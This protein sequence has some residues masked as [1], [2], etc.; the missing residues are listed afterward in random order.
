MS[1]SGYFLYLLVETDDGIVGAIVSFSTKIL[2]GVAVLPARS[3]TVADRVSI[4]S[5][6]PDRVGVDVKASDT[7]LAV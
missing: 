5:G 6:A 2:S 1:P 3:E 7:Q 4:A